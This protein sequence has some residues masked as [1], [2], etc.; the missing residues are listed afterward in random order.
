MST[1][2]DT[3]E[4]A[5]AR[6]LANPDSEYARAVMAAQA[7]ATDSPEPTA[8]EHLSDLERQLETLQGELDS[9]TSAVRSGD[10]DAA[11][12][13]NLPLMASR[14]ATLRS[15]IATARTAVAEAERQR[16]SRQHQEHERQ[17]EDSVTQARSERETVRTLYGQLAVALGRYCTYGEKAYAARNALSTFLPDPSRDATLFEATD[18]AR[19]DPREELLRSDFRPSWRSSDATCSYQ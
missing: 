7:E 2:P 4:A 18:F 16:R 8:D 13:A 9:V 6:N 10:A 1:Q 11:G 19:L 12:R 5:I 15:E 14:I 3:L 17:F